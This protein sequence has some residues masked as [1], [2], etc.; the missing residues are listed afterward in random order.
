[1]RLRRRVVRRRRRQRGRA[2]G[3]G[4]RQPLDRSRRA[5]RSGAD[6]GR[7]W[8]IRNLFGHEPRRRDGRRI[9]RG[10]LVGRSDCGTECDRGASRR[11][12]R[13]ASAKRARSCGRPSRPLR[14]DLRRQLR[15]A[16]A[17][18]LVD[19]RHGRGAGEPWPTDSDRSG[20]DGLREHGAGGGGRRGEPSEGLRR[21]AGRD[22]VRDHLRLRLRHRGV[23]RVRRHGVQRQPP[24]RAGRAGWCPGPA[25]D[26]DDQRLG[27]LSDRRDRLPRRRRHR[28]P[29]R[30]EDRDR[31]GA[32]H[33][34]SGLLHGAHRGRGRRRVRLG[35]A[36]RSH[37]TRGRSAGALLRRPR[38][39][40][41][42][43]GESHAL[44]RRRRLLQHRLPDRSDLL[45][46]R[47]GSGVRAACNAG[48]RGLRPRGR[49]LR[50]R[51]RR[52]RRR[53]GRLRRSGLRR[54]P[55]L[56]E[57]RLLRRSSI[58]QLL[59]RA[60]ESVLRRRRVLRGGLRRGRVLLC[61]RVGFDLCRR[62]R[63]VVRRPVRGGRRRGDLRQRDRRRRRRLGRLR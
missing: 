62:G 54:I 61:D 53:V 8:R 24:H 15:A 40:R 20:P 47:M 1:M 13:D 59:H 26:R 31:G 56:H 37:S 30:L 51:D 45:P 29:H 22:D 48:V 2:A 63:A 9:R 10:R 52:R 35:G 49:D 7:G 28:R 46:D 12:G 34:G 14:V 11:R 23:A 44:L 27:L 25:R 50:Q 18:A 32:D 19:R 38:G 41:L 21:A 16:D 42:L 33:E 43:R 36:R 3:R 39:G 57:V 4:E 58:Q 55:E 60:F 17:R 5:G 6:H